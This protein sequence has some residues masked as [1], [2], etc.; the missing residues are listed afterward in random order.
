MWFAAKFQVFPGIGRI[1]FMQ[2]KF[3]IGFFEMHIRTD[4]SH[5]I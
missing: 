3:D 5:M 2:A 1:L 4:A